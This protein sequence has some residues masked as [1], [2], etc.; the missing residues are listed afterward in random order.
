MSVTDKIDE[1][2][3]SGKINTEAALSLILQVLL[4]NSA[5]DVAHR[6]TVEAR[7]TAVEQHQAKNPSLSFLFRTKYKVAVP[8]AVL[9]TLLIMASSQYI[10]WQIIATFVASQAGISLP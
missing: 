5:A 9:A 8:V 3:S 2:L 10:S 4:E 7:L 1:M 6:N